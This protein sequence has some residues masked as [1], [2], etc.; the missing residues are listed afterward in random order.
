MPYMYIIKMFHFCLRRFQNMPYMY[1]MKMFHFCLRRFQCKRYHLQEKGVLFNLSDLPISNRCHCV[2]YRKR[3]NSIRSV[4]WSTLD[5]SK[6]KYSGWSRLP[7]IKTQYDCFK[8]INYVLGH[9]SRNN[10][11]HKMHSNNK[12]NSKK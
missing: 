12:R 3:I 1:I 11:N 10:N 7:V 4:K 9:Y 6:T 5:N 8:N 2:L